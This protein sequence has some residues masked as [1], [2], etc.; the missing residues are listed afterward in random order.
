MSGDSLITM[1]YPVMC[2][3]RSTA[4]GI[5]TEDDVPFHR[6][7]GYEFYL[8]LGGSVNFY[9]GNSVFSPVR[10]DLYILE[11]DSVHRA[12]SRGPQQYE[13]FIINL[14]RDKMK[15]YLSQDNELAKSYESGEQTPMRRI[16]LTAEEIDT[17]CS[18]A[19]KLSTAVYLKKPCDDLLVDAYL[20]EIL[21][22]VSRRLVGNRN[23]D[24]QGMVPDLVAD[25]KNYIFEHL[26]EQITLSDLSGQFFFNGKYISAM[27]KKYTGMTLRSYVLDQR[28]ML[29]KRLLREGSN[30]SEACYHSGFLD[31]TNFIRSFTRTVGMSPGKYSRCARAGALGKF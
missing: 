2:Y 31:Y 29:A 27:F 5:Q 10:G 3:S 13:R 17:Y 30:V 16:R 19:E 22:L 4:P 24:G 25:V 6:H 21:V 28:I 12:I 11:P 20:T 23:Q 9:F 7:D 15:E 14:R 26:T 1:S 8:F 18:I